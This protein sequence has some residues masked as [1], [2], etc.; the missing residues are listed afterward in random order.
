MQGEDDRSQTVFVEVATYG[1][2]LEQEL[3]IDLD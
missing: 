3:D 1:K 2:Q